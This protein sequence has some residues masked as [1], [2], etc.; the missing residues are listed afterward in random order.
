MDCAD[1]NTTSWRLMRRSN[2]NI[3]LSAWSVSK[4]SQKGGGCHEAN[5]HS[6]G[7]GCALSGR[8]TSCTDQGFGCDRCEVVPV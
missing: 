6:R 3:L 5:D 4:G 8:F 1:I 7:N 2:N